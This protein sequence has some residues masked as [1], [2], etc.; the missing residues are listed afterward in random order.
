M[1]IR[2]IDRDPHRSH[3]YIDRGEAYRYRGEYDKAIADATE[4]L[5][6]HPELVMGLVNRAAA[7]LDKGAG[8]QAP[9]DSSSEERRVGARG[10][11]RWSSEP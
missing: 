5:G 2:S 8:P 10:R 4:A 6:R 7:S 11:S 3:P 1:L 9:P